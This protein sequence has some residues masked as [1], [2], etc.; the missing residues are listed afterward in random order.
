MATRFEKSIGVSEFAQLIR[1]AGGSITNGK[2]LGI[3]KSGGFNGYRIYI[4]QSEN[5]SVEGWISAK[6]ARRWID[7]HSE[8]TEMLECIKEYIKQQ[9]IEAK[10][11]SDKKF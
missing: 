4:Y 3:A 2:L 9:E 11:L 8:E 5:G 7:A 1:D 10:S 6:E